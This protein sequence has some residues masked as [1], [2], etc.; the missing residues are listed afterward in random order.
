MGEGTSRGLQLVVAPP[1]LPSVTVQRLSEQVCP[2]CRAYAVCQAAAGG[3]DEGGG[4][5]GGNPGLFQRVRQMVGKFF[6]LV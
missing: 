2:V 3:G 4:G 5:G 6:G 1:T